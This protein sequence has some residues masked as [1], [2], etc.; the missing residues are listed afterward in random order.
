MDQIPDTPN[1]SLTAAPLDRSING[2]NAEYLDA[3]YNRWSMDP[4]SVETPWQ[5]FFEGF[6]LGTRVAE[7][8]TTEDNA[9]L[10]SAKAPTSMPSSST[11][12]QAGQHL[13]AQNRVFGLVHR[14]RTL[15]HRAAHLDPLGLRPQNT[16]GLLLES[17]GLSDAN[18]DEKFDSQG[19]PLPDQTPLRDIVDL[20]SRTYCGHIGTE[21]M[22]IQDIQQRRWVQEH[23]ESIG[24]KP[25]FPTE[26]RIRMLRNLNKATNLEAFLHTRYVGQ[27]R[28]GLEGCESLIPM[29]NE[30]VETAAD[31][32]VEELSLGMAHRGRLNVLVNVLHK[33]YDELFTEFEESLLEDFTEGGGDVKYHRGYSADFETIGGK[34]IHLTLASNP[35]HLEYGHSVVL[36]RARAKQRLRSDESR[37]M[38]VP[39][40]IHGDASFP[41]QGI[42]AEMLNLSQLDGYTVG[43][44]IHIVVNNQIGFTTNPHDGFSGHYCTDLAKTID[45]PIFHV[46]GDDPEACS[47]VALLALKYRQTFHR[48]VVID[49]WGYRRHGHNESD[50]PTFTQPALYTAI[51][52]QPTVL[53]QYEQYLLN[54]KVISQPEL[55]AMDQEIH[56]ALDASQQVV[57][58]KPVP[59]PVEAFRNVWRGL[60]QEYTED[61]V[62][63]AAT[64]EE[65]KLVSKA[66][67]TVPEG[68][69]PH[70]KLKRLLSYRGQAVAEDEPIDWG[71]G[72]MLSYG[73]LLLH[74]HAVRLTG[75]DSER[76][77]FS[78][79]HAVIFDQVTN[80]PYIPL[81]HIADDQ[82]KVCL[83]NSPLSEAAC[84]GFEYGYSLGDPRMLVIWEAQFGDFA[85]SAQV[86][87]DQ[88]V[89]SAEIK[90]KRSSGLTLFLP[91]GYEGMGPEHSS[92]RLERYLTLCAHNN[93]VVCNPTTP[94]QVFHM[95]QRQMERAFRKPLVVMT[96]KSLLRNPLATSRYSDL[97]EGTFKRVIDCP[98]AKNPERI[99]RLLF[100]TGKVYYDLVDQ[101][102]KAEPNDIAIVRVEQLYPIHD[103]DFEAIFNK[104]K[105]AEEI[106]WVQEE[107]RN[108]GAWQ[109]IQDIFRH[110][111]GVMLDY[112]G[113][114]ANASPA[115][116]SNKMHIAG[117][118]R[119]KNAA[120]GIPKSDQ[121]ANAGRFGDEDP[122]HLII[123]TR[124][125]QPPKCKAV[126]AGSMATGTTGSKKT[127]K[128]TTGPRKKT[129]R[130]K[131]KKTAS[132]RG[133]S[134]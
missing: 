120:V 88:F 10:S 39:L 48:D 103:P 43:G 115:A 73:I 106:I 2:W 29:L 95:L 118:Q 77:T 27:K 76:G 75:Q 19:L 130:S 41:G 114:E 28:F 54:Q 38:C 34:P 121:K 4:A 79:R 31:G 81:N 58:T 133:K 78:H 37:S 84:V 63:T 102:T 122:Y 5:R 90:W 35:S 61:A 3:M 82:A 24:G 6:D 59:S 119:I 50:E 87:L 80:E 117:Q 23:L 112:I 25:T 92:A 9:S 68:F 70:R 33:T 44:T 99:K 83:H 20:L 69:T 16:E 30:I 128:K 71:L 100:C 45:A 85:N 110:H 18:L 56:N 134:R 108:M 32:G 72:E 127:K 91:H 74:G 132:R 12:D 42:V 109:F 67:C 13:W 94:A 26:Q 126:L 62:K 11:E 15:G 51:N 93:Q 101:M 64:L 105:N 98:I 14:Y 65:L 55:E 40:L 66:L 116:G 104:Y 113:R 21:Y 97:I 36:G 125:Q 17:V 22:H 57:K 111:F 107:P 7:N 46:N 53:K 96:P 123:D 1:E 131:K 49:L 52:N 86:L 129:T 47:F 124:R 8:E 60:S 89:A